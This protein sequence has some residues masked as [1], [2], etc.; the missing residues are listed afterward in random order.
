MG[1]KNKIETEKGLIIKNEIEKK[2]GN[3]ESPDID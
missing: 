2:N 3:V 1:F